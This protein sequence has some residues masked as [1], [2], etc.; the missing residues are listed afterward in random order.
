[1]Y[2]DY[3]FILTVYHLFIQHNIFK[4]SIDRDVLNLGYGWESRYLLVV[5]RTNHIA[6]GEVQ[7]RRLKGWR[8]LWGTF[9]RDPE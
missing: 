7:L 2:P 8:T 9:T 4:D 1:M 5:G 6:V 3:I